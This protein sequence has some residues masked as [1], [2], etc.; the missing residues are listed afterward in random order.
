MQILTSN[1]RAEARAYGI[2]PLPIAPK[3]SSPTGLPRV[4]LLGP[5]DTATLPREAAPSH[6]P[7]NPEQT[8]LRPPETKLLE[9]PDNLPMTVAQ[10][11]YVAPELIARWRAEAS[12]DRETP[13]ER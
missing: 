13:E 7:R 2:F 9:L 5:S 1:G 6:G 11:V 3:P 10:R 12:S 8:R 4:E